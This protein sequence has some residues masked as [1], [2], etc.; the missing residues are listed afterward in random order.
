MKSPRLKPLLWLCVLLWL[1][2]LF[3]AASGIFLII[4]GSGVYGAGALVIAGLMAA[5]GAG[6]WQLKRWGVFLFGLLS[7]LG[8]VNYLT[9]LL[10]RYSDLSQASLG[11]ILT[12][13][14]SLF[15]SVLIPVGLFYLTIILWRKA[16]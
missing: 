7:L 3:F 5:C 6:L 15:A 2:G 16:S 9:N 8:S 12:A 1:G 10:N 14:F 4:N 11:V 13:L